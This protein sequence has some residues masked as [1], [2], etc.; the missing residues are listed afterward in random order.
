MNEVLAISESE[1][2]LYGVQIVNE[3]ISEFNLPSTLSMSNVGEDGKLAFDIADYA[4]HS[5]PLTEPST[6]EQLWHLS[7]S[8]K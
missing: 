8:A 7:V 1:L 3:F 5:T 4:L 6:V 2:A